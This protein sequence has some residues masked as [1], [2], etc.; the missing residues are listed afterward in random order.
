M[1]PVGQRPH[2]L[3]AFLRGQPRVDQRPHQRVAEQRHLTPG[4]RRRLPP[5]H[6]YQYLTVV[7]DT[8]PGEAPI[9]IREIKDVFLCWEPGSRGR[10]VRV[11]SSQPPDSTAT[12]RATLIAAS[13]AGRARRNAARHTPIWATASPSP[14]PVGATRAMSSPS[15]A[16]SRCS[17]CVNRSRISPARHPRPGRPAAHR[18]GRP[19]HQ[20]RPAGATPTRPRR[21]AAPTRSPPPHP[22]GDPA[23]T[24]AAAH[25][26]ARSHRHRVNEQIARRSRILSTAPLASRTN[27]RATCPH[28]DSDPAHSGHRNKPS[29]SICSTT[30]GSGP[31]VSN[32][33]SGRRRERPF[34]DWPASDWGEGRLSV[35]DRITLDP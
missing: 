35:N 1:V 33:A 16:T 25:A 28:R 17:S 2:Q 5:G 18:R 8:G 14:L 9:S 27:R 20:R 24:Q 19:V 21:P 26:C 31:T 12:A 23:G 3:A 22:A 29:A 15:A 32:A 11:P 30:A 6:R 4:H 34:P 7:V 13:T 10:R